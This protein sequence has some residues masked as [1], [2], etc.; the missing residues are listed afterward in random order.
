[1]GA[2]V[3]NDIACNATATQRTRT[4]ISSSGRAGRHERADGSHLTSWRR[5]SRRR[6]ATISSLLAAECLVGLLDIGRGM[7][8]ADPP[9]AI[10]DG[11]GNVAE[12]LSMLA[13]T[14]V[15]TQGLKCGLGRLIHERLW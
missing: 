1:V 14:L 11:L 7:V 13:P 12:Q 3:G 5:G 2:G 15:A 9:F 4:R 8:P 10:T 6:G